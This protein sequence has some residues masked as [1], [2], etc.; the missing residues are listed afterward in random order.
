MP[1][2]EY[3]ST[4]ETS[5]ATATNENAPIIFHR[6]WGWWSDVLSMLTFIRNE[7]VFTINPAIPVE[8][9]WQPI[10]LV[11]GYDEVDIIPVGNAR[12]AGELIR[13]TTRT[14]QLGTVLQTFV[15]EYNASWLRSFDTAPTGFDL[16][17]DTRLLQNYAFF[18]RS[19]YLG[20]KATGKYA[21]KA[22]PGRPKRF[23]FRYR[24]RRITFADYQAGDGQTE[25]TFSNRSHFYILKFNGERG[26]VCGVDD[27]VNSVPIVAEVG[28]DVLIRVRH[29][30]FYRW[31]NGNQRA[32]VYG[33]FAS[34]TNDYQPAANGAA[35]VGV[36]ALKS[37]RI[38][39]YEYAGAGAYGANNL[40]A[41]HEAN[42]E[43]FHECGQ[44]SRVPLVRIDDD[45]PV[46]VEVVP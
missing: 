1:L 40:R 18:D 23:V 3:I 43:V 32:S 8:N 30:Y 24:T 34:K 20:V 26:Q 28:T 41:H 45:P 38:S 22:G 31:V 27:E 10:L 11:S 9:S 19:S 42:I 37:Q 17:P 36:P 16:H 12:I 5:S 44:N 35:F 33:S 46:Q 29:Y 15:D 14:N 7:S 2:D 4:E 39:A 13:C 25:G 21:V 6:G